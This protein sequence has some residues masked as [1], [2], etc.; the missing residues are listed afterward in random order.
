M[1][2]TLLPLLGLK[3]C[4]ITAPAESHFSLSTVHVPSS[5]VPKFIVKTSSSVPI[6]CFPLNSRSLWGRVA[7]DTATAGAVDPILLPSCPS[8]SLSCSRG[9]DGRS[10]GGWSRGNNWTGETGLKY[11]LRLTWVLPNEAWECSLPPD[12]DTGGVV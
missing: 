3:V 2:A 11:S 8:F 10:C 12:T 5:V 6:C 7:P 9:K 1:E 4:T